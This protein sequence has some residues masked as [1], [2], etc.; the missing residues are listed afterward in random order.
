MANY[1]VKV[2]DHTGSQADWLKGLCKA[3]EDLFN[4]CLEGTSDTVT[5]TSGTGQQ[6][7]NLIL[8]FVENVDQSFIQQKMPGGAALK[9]T[10][11]GHTRTRGKKTCTEFYKFILFPG[12]T[13]RR[14]ARYEGYAKTAVHES[15]HNL[16]PGWSEDDMH[17]GPGGGGL[18]A[19][20]PRLPPTQKNKEL[21][22]KG[23][24]IKNDQFL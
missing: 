2:V 22:R 1:S 5:V 20:P 9:P 16:F 4:K 15:L 3:I 10:L 12:E 19:S 24:S 18:A 6:S 13:A 17:G 14:P 11:A 21:I 7:D 8:H 23:L